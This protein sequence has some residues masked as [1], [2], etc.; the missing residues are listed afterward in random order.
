MTIPPE[1]NQVFTDSELKGTNPVATHAEQNPT[2]SPLEGDLAEACSSLGLPPMPS[3]TIPDTKYQIV[4]A[5][6]LK[7]DTRK[8]KGGESKSRP[9]KRHLT[10]AELSAVYYHLK[11]F[12][13]SEHILLFRFILAT[14][15]KMQESKDLRWCDLNCNTGQ[16]TFK[17]RV[18]YI[19]QS[20]TKEFLQYRDKVAT[21][22]DQS[23]FEGIYRENW[24]ALQTALDR[25]GIT[26]KR[27]WQ[28]VRYSYIARF[29]SLYGDK[30]RLKKQLG[31]VSL[32]RL[33][34]Y[35]LQL[36]PKAMDD[37]FQITPSAELAA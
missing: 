21:A 1:K 14:G 19:P 13:N 37:F 30:K 25:L 4:N 20:L 5:P 7:K 17:N 12:R 33:P 9:K 22:D 10:E 27:A 36:E 24:R 11:F 29:M 31:L 6:E 18:V 26:T 3:L 34:K 16:V 8:I 35:L 23:I 28:A 32:R 2:K 15:A